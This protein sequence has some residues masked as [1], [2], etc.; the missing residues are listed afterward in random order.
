VDHSSVFGQTG[1]GE[2]LRFAEVRR[3]VRLDAEAAPVTIVLTAVS[4]ASTGALHVTTTP[5]SAAVLVDGIAR[6]QAPVDVVGL[7]PGPH[8]VEVTQIGYV[9]YYDR[10]EV[11]AST[12][13]PVNVSLEPPVRR[14]AEDETG[15][16]HITSEPSGAQVYLDG[17]PMGATP[18]TLESVAV[19]SH[20]VRVTKPYYGDQDID[21]VAEPRTVSRAGVRLDPVA[22]MLTLDA[23]F[24]ND[25]STLYIDPKAIGPL[26]PTQTIR[27]AAGLHQLRVQSPTGDV[28]EQPIELMGGPQRIQLRGAEYFGAVTVLSDAPLDLLLVNGR[29]VALPPITVRNVRR[30]AAEVAGIS[31]DRYFTKTATGP[32]AAQPRRRDAVFGLLCTGSRDLRS[33][34]APDSVNPVDME[35][36]SRMGF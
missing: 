2:V 23:D 33:A 24:A 9:A 25:P 30:G 14:R 34:C 15:I 28:I 5:D 11:S 7:V 22:A 17:R 3:T 12:V 10:V 35:R 21:V 26:K 16:L 29:R 13:L 20:K 31:G 32:R 4:T 19:G 6:G 36:T 8:R 27:L 1:C 18:A